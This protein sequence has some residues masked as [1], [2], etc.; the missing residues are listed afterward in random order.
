MTTHGDPPSRLA[1]LFSTAEIKPDLAGGLAAFLVSLPLSMMIGLVAFAPLGK[2]YAVFA[3]ISGIYGAIF[4]SLGAL[5]FGARSIMVSGPR[6]ASA[7]ILA[8][9]IEQLLRSDQLYFPAGQT[10][11]NVIGIAFFAVLLAGLIQFL[12]GFFRMGNVVKNI[13]HPVASGFINSTALLI[14]LGQVWIL[15]D[16]PKQE[17]LFEIIPLLSEMRPLTMVPALATI[18]A[19]IVTA[20]W[21]KFLPSTV[22]G[23]LLGSAVYY[24][25]KEGMGGYDLGATLGEVTTPFPVPQIMGMVPSLYAGGDIWAVIIMVLPASIAMAAL[26]SLDTL[27]CLSALDQM[28]EERSD[29]NRELVGHGVGNMIAGM[30]GGV[31]GSGGMVRTKPGFEAGGRTQRMIVVSCLLMFATAVLFFRYFEFIP[32]SVISGVLLVLAYQLFDRWSLDLVKNVFRKKTE[33]RSALISDLV[34]ILL[35]VSVAL[36]FN[37]IVAVSMGL[38][39]AVF[40]FISRMSHSLVRNEFRG[41]AL[42]A[43]SVW[44]Q[45]RNAIL[46]K[47]GHRIVVLELEGA[48]FFGT[49][50]VLEERVDALMRDGVTHVIFDMKR[51][52]NIDSTGCIA[53]KRINQKIRKAGGRLALGYILEERRKDRDRRVGERDGK[54]IERR[55]RG[56][57]RPLWL[58]LRGSGVIG[59]IGKD[60]VFSDTDGALVFCENELINIMGEA[61]NLSRRLKNRVPPMLSGLSAEE[62]RIVRKRFTREKYKKGNVVFEQGAAGDALYF[63]ARGRVD[64]YVDLGEGGY[65]KRVQTFKRGSIFGE[66][67][68]LDDKP[69]AASI[70]AT[71]DTVCYRLSIEEFARIKD[72]NHK[73]ALK[74]FSNF[75]IMLSERIRSAN[76][77]ISE[78]EK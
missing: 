27:L 16:I 19:M 25:M 62:V 31:I 51:L 1:T 59:A 67:A 68:I 77:M 7:L 66:M 22:T 24:A 39:V 64:V 12:F 30:L 73:L 48:I 44:D 70:I 6:A 9:L 75:A 20:R 74:L 54:K 23:I 47:C 11:P 69:R 26:A 10:I 46:E 78:L 71:D 35:V 4:L 56:S 34:V 28:R 32:R 50:D 60:A 58:F 33:A 8:S 15:F 29:S 18:A 17:F 49:A 41:P 5:F 40:I 13:P 53:L 65:K 63:L 2:D 21:M 76:V 61:E 36:I 14:I 37:L 38:V 52:A 43:R 57:R 42:H 55:K 72:T 45:E 3:A